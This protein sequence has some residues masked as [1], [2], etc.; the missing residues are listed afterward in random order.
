MD[1][2][3]AADDSNVVAVHC[4]AGKGRTGTVIAS[5]FLY[6]AEFSTT[7]DALSY[8]GVCRTVSA[9][10]GRT[11]LR[12]RTVALHHRSATPYQIYYHVWRPCF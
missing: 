3:L 7:E 12:C 9:G 1:E 8:F 5:Y 11:V 6:A 4:K 10:L 2:F